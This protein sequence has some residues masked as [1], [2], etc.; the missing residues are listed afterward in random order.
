MPQ[1]Q[2]K[3]GSQK[4]STTPQRKYIPTYTQNNNKAIFKQLK[5]VVAETRSANVC[6]T[7]LRC[8]ILAHQ[9]A[10]I[11]AIKLH[12]HQNDWRT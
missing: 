3:T 7:S 1:K 9:Q 5:G 2:K 8:N 10:P 11:L 4:G 12:W 6:Y